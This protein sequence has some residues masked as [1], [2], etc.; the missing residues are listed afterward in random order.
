MREVPRCTGAGGGARWPRLPGLGAPPTVAAPGGGGG[1]DRCGAGGMRTGG[2]RTGGEAMEPGEMI[3][4]G[5]CSGASVGGGRCGGGSA[6][7]AL[8][9]SSG[10][11]TS[12]RM[13][14]PV[15]RRAESSPP[16]WTDDDLR[17]FAGSILP[18]VAWRT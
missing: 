18:C 9:P 14:W 5:M 17:S 3:G 16:I 15:V 6:L 10:A 8:R 2:L 1:G 11:A 4:V 13:S 12:L 7:V